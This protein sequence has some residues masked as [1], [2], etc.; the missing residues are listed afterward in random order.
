ME[1][2]N[3]ICKVIISLMCLGMAVLGVFARHCDD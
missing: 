2:F 3:F 1:I